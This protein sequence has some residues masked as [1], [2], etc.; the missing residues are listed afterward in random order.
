MIDSLVDYA[1]KNIWCNP[2]QDNQFIIQPKRISQAGGVGGKIQV[3]GRT[4]KL[5]NVQKRYHVFQIGQIS[6]KILNLYREMPD[7]QVDRWMGSY[8]TV[9]TNHTI[10]QIYN[11]KGVMIPGYLCYFMYMDERNVIIA[12]EEASGLPVDFKF[13][14]FYVRFYQNAYFESPRYTGDLKLL[15]VGERTNS[16]SD[17]TRLQT[18]YL[19][20]KTKTGHVFVYINGLLV[21]SLDLITAKAYDHVEMLY[22]SS[23]ARIVSFKL[24]TLPT[25]NS[26]KDNIRKYLLSYDLTDRRTIEYMDDQDVYVSN[27]HSGRFKAIYGY[28]HHLAA[29]S[30]VTHRDYGLSVPM[31]NEYIQQLKTI[32]GTPIAD[33]DNWGVKLY[34]R[35]AGYERGLVYENNRLHELYKLPHSDVLEALVGTGDSTSIWRADVL[36]TSPY[37]VLMSKYAYDMSRND[38]ISALG[39]NALSVLHGDTPVKLAVDA[40]NR[41]IPVPELLRFDTTVYEYD[42]NGLLLGWNSVGHG[43]EYTPHHA[44]ATYFE[45]L[46]G[47]G[48]DTPD[49]I[50]TTDVDIPKPIGVNWRIYRAYYSYG[51]LIDIWEDITDNPLIQVTDTHIRYLGTDAGYYFMVRTDKTFLAYDLD[52]AVT[53]YLIKFPLAEFETRKY[54]T[55]KKLYA[56]PVPGDELDVFMNG[57]TLIEGI[58]YI[59]DFPNLYV[60]NK[61]YLKQPVST[62]MQ[63]FHIR[64]RGLC[65]NDMRWSKPEDVGFI[66]HGVLSNNTK[67]DVRDDRVMRIS[68]DGG[69]RTKSDVVFSEDSDAISIVNSKNG[70]PYALRDI[71]VPMREVTDVDTYQ[72]RAAS[73]LIDQQVSDYMSQELPQFDR[74]SLMA[75]PTKHELYSPFLARIIYDLVTEYIP[76]STYTANLTDQQV[77][78]ICKPYEEW[79]KCDPISPGNY[80]DERYVSIHPHTHH[81]KIMVNLFAY[82]FMLRVVRLYADNRIDLSA[83]LTVESDGT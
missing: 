32:T 41:S 42:E 64:F 68:L 74:G 73:R 38:V 30:M 57:R 60:I 63:R 12:I 72:I 54:D 40:V 49:I 2:K 67:F 65:T 37:N 43:V 19:D 17:I 56:M 75:I 36:E 4:I 23:I 29:M 62:E 44:E 35:K 11:Q 9:N 14:K 61:A 77:I 71:M 13:D 55:V 21:D 48:T 31:V 69:I 66:E 26:I 59:V 5:P 47:V 80:I 46:R 78:N 58:D 34:V 81:T 53:G 39:Y 8:N 1:I 82:R 25:F 51:T 76:P 18:Q 28:R 52:V 20:L 3:V 27:A 33:T 16:I 10:V 50:L 83:F 6:P 7:W 70:Q 45:F 15:A 24:G 22:D 79:L